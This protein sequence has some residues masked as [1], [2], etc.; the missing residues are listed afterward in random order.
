MQAN[1]QRQI[2]PEFAG[3]RDNLVPVA[4]MR[5]T[6]FTSGGFEGTLGIA[7]MRRVRTQIGWQITKIGEPI[8]YAQDPN[9]GA[10]TA[11][12]LAASRG[13][14]VGMGKASL[15][16]DFRAR[17]FAV[18]TGTAVSGGVDMASSSFGSDLE[19]WRVGA[20]FEHGSKLFKSHN[21]IYGA[22]FTMGNNLPLWNENAAGGTN[23]RGYLGGQFRG[24]TQASVKVEYHFPLF[25]VSSLDFRGLVFYDGQAV[26]YRNL[27][28]TP[29][30]DPND[31]TGNRTYLQR[32]TPDQRNYL[33]TTKAGFSASD[34]IHNAVGA[35]LRFF[36]RSVA[37]PLV[38][39][40]AGYG[41]EARTW[42]F[43]LIVG[44]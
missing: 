2:I 6:H 27:P 40:D 26:W 20:G 18:M 7:W 25:S 31:P 21:F 37:V 34:N 12:T 39:F 22:G 10:L 19:Y 23:L 43:F 14:V 1:I 15:S 13:A 36:L 42:R 32:D 28:N 44:A 4:P 41:I 30:V 38:G 3:G 9:T 5:E 16:F 33:S 29:V 24:D 8:S 17:E 35:G 11:S